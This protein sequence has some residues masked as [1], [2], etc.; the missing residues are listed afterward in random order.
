MATN[1]YFETGDN[2][3]ETNFQLVG[4][5]ITCNT[6]YVVSGYAV[7][8][9]GS[10]DV[11]IAAGTC[12]VNGYVIVEDAAQTNQGCTNNATNGVYIEADGDVEITTGAPTSANSLKLATVVTSGGSISSITHEQ[13]ITQGANVCAVKASDETVNNSATLQDDAEL[14]LAAKVR[15]IWDIEYI[16]II[17]QDNAGANF[18]C[19]IDIPSGGITSMAMGPDDDGSA[20][21]AATGSGGVGAYNHT[22]AVTGQEHAILHAIQTGGVVVIKAV[23]WIGATAGDIQL[24]WAQNGATVADTKVLAG[25]TMIGRRIFG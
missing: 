14:V 11:D 5:A 23:V 6:A 22:G 18:K 9:S 13:G 2:L 21:T 19:A 8:D 17:E 12:V 4:A 15:E 1:V 20:G 25:S 24:T 10:L 16:L 3:D 7:T